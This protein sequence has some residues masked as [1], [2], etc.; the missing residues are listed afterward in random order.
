MKL[1]EDAK[2]GEEHKRTFHYKD[3][4]IVYDETKVHDEAEKYMHLAADRGD[5]IAEPAMKALKRLGV[6]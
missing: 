6:Q 2:R 4:L 5:K 3:I 1:N